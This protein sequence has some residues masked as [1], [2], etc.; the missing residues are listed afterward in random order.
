VKA[1]LPQWI[2]EADLAHKGD[3]IFPLDRAGRR[4]WFKRG[5]PTGSTAV[6][7]LGYRLTGLPFLRPVE[8]KSASEAA[9]WEAAKL[10]HLAEKGLP[11]PAVVAEGEGFFV[12]EDRGEGLSGLLKRAEPATAGHWLEGV[13]DA[14]AALHRAGEYHG[15]SQIRNFVLDA[16]EEVGI[17]DFEESFPADSDPKALQFR[18]LFLLLYSLHRQKQEADYPALLRRYMNASGNESFEEELRAL[19]HRFRWLAKLVEPERVRRRLG[20]DAEILHRLFE[21]IKAS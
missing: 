13:A 8:R 15:A 2:V 5:R 16:G 6:H 7:A 10:R 14:L 18:D 20:R 19:Y 4:Y 3:E 12:M 11:V 9:A 17:I 1:E 21:S